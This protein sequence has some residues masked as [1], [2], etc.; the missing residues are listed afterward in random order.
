MQRPGFVTLDFLRDGRTRLAII[1]V[2]A[3]EAR[4]HR[5]LGAA[6]SAGGGR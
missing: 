1:Q 4:R 2:D 6:C 3:R 5:G